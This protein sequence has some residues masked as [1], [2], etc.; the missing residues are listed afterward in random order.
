MELWEVLVPASNAK[1]KENFSYEHHKAWDEYVKSLSG[2]LTIFRTV[3]GEWVSD[4]GEIFVD[5]MIPVRIA[6]S[7]EDIE[8]II[9]FTI[10]HYSQLAVM[11]YKVSDEV[12][13]RGKN[14]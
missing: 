4:N 2:G 3:K 13:I 5:R 8:K 14:V 9:D 6:C 1:R 10:E 7:R 12:I 11:A